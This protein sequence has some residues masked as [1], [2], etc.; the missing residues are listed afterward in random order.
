MRKEYLAIPALLLAGLLIG[1]AAGE[2]RQPVQNQDVRQG[3]NY[4]NYVTV[5]KYDAQAGVWNAPVH[6]VF[7]PL[8][9]IGS[10]RIRGALNGSTNLN[11]SNI[12]LANCTATFALTDTRLCGGTAGN[13]YNDTNCGMGPS[14]GE[15]VMTPFP[16]TLGAWNLTKQWTS[17]C[18]SVIVNA[19]G[20]YNYTGAN[21][22]LIAE[23]NFT[24]VTLQTND[25]LNVTWGIQV[26]T[27]TV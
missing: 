2:F 1:L 26:L 16:G 25:K 8:T 11:A 17:T 19:T 13:E 5:Q 21:N 27:P 22:N 12:T 18:D 10:S 6:S 9:T 4:V 3:L 7:D 23:V 20:L 15:A 14:S 24:S